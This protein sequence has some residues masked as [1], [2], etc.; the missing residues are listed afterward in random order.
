MTTDPRNVQH[1][2]A[3]VIGALVQSWR[4]TGDDSVLEVVRDAAA[5]RGG[6]EH[7]PVRTGR[8]TLRRGRAGVEP[9]RC[10]GALGDDRL[11]ERAVDLALRL[12]PEWPGPDVTHGRAGLG[13]AL[14]HLHRVSGD[15]RL[16]TAAARCADS[17]LRDVERNSNGVIAWRT[18]AGF[19]SSFAGRTFY[20][21][22]HG[23][24]GIAT[25][26]LAM[27]TASGRDDCRG[28]V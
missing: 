3:G 4:C 12:S 14:L 25:F 24:A 11:V 18:S 16:L 7:D 26:L 19:R 13:L 6:G 17:L 23:T 9:G 27:A 21:F 22:A 1:G 28:V 10:R 20:G 5:W 15:G 2:A 8:G